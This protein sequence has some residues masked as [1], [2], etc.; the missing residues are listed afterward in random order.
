MGKDVRHKCVKSLMV[1]HF[2]IF[3]CGCNQPKSVHIS[4]L[5]LQRYEIKLKVES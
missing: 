4:F 3:Y 1:F 5:R 2:S